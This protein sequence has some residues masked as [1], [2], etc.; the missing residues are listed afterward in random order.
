M[1]CCC[2]N[3]AICIAI[4]WPNSATDCGSGFDFCFFLLFPLCDFVVLVLS[5]VLFLLRLG[6][7]E[8][9]CVIGSRPGAKESSSPS[10][11]D[12]DMRV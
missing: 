1:P 5:G 11:S 7:F 3:R 9:S 10:L 8:P 2:I 6:G 4:F 12:I